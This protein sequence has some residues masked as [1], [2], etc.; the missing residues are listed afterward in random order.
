M[1]KELQTPWIHNTLIDGESSLAYDLFQ[2]IGEPQ[3]GFVTGLHGHEAVV[4]GIVR[5]ALNH[6]TVT[7]ELKYSHIRISHAHP[8]AIHAR[9]RDG[10]GVDINR[11]FP[12][13][14]EMPTHPRARLL[15][16]CTDK[17]PLHYMFSFHEDHEDS[18]AP[19]YF[20]DIPQHTDDSIAEDLVHRLRKNLVGV[21]KKQGFGTFT[22]SD[23]PDLGNWI[24]DGYVQTTASDHYDT[25]YETHLVDLGAR[26]LGSVK[27]AF[28]FEI[29]GC[30]TRAEKQL[31]V[32]LVLDTFILPFLNETLSHTR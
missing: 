9:T 26:G 17:F 32:H 15:R 31:H 4:I 30:G 21:I 3:V 6:R 13:P 25:T 20:Y 27:R 16:L 18:P 12:V 1:G 8:A 22:G 28:V 11:Q 2:G 29:P 7:G 10:D 19:F 24:T 5:T 14:G 23:A